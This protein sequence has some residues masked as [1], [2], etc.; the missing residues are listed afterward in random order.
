MDEGISPALFFSMV[1][2]NRLMLCKDLRELKSNH[3]RNDKFDGS[4]KITSFFNISKMWYNCGHN[5][6]IPEIISHYLR[7][8]ISFVTPNHNFD[9]TMGYFNG[10]HGSGPLKM[11]ANNQVDYVTNDI[12]LSENLWNPKMIALSSAI[13]Q[14]YAISFITKKESIMLSIGSYMNVFNLLIWMLLIISIILIALIHGL[15]VIIE[16]THKITFMKFI[17]ELIFGY[18]N[19]LMSGQTSLILSKINSRHFIMYLIPLLSIIV[20]NLRSSFIYSNMVSPPKQWCESIDCFA[21]SNFKFYA[22]E[23]DFGLS[24][25]IKKNDKQFKSIASR[26][27]VVH[28]HR[29][30]MLIHKKNY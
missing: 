12:Y 2:S 14:S 5:T 6:V 11:I 24:L 23:G 7:L 21:K 13:D 22:M 9:G 26:I 30:L 15:I 4:F 1:S 20:V 25:L 28:N 17:S 3:N 18:F 29:N 8:N 16:R 10:T 27:E 19:L